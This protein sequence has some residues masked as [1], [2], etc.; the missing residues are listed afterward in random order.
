MAWLVCWSFRLQFQ[1]RQ[2]WGFAL[3]RLVFVICIVAFDLLM[4]FALGLGHRQWYCIELAY[5]S[6]RGLAHS[7]TFRE[8]EGGFEDAPAFGLRQY[9]AASIFS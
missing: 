4:G 2:K 5:Q 3:F 1:D 7:K 8:L 9:S 6:A